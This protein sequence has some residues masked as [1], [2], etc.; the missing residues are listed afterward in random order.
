VT[1]TERRRLALVVA[2]WVCAVV[3]FA[4]DGWA[5]AAAILAAIGF[6]VAAWLWGFIVE[7]NVQRD[8]QR[9]QAVEAV[10]ARRERELQ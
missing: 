6:G 1:F 8:D 3:Y 5:S 9:R 2:C 7:V 4:T 10:W